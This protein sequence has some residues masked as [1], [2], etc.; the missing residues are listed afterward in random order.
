MRKLCFFN[1]VN[2]PTYYYFRW[3][4]ESKDVDVPALVAGAIRNVE[5]KPYF[6]P[7]W[8]FPSRVRSELADLLETQVYYE[9]LPLNPQ[10]DD[11]PN[12]GA[13]YGGPSQDLQH[14]LTAWAASQ[15]AYGEVAAAVMM[16]F[17]KSRPDA[18]DILVIP[19]Q[20]TDQEEHVAQ[21]RTDPSPPYPS[22]A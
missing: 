4:L 6:M 1:F 8:D 5:E 15:I 10:T 7:E 2:E 12:L 9:V 3:L 19:Q 14:A 11:V 13:D 21:G 16:A 22:D 20:D 18:T 17:G